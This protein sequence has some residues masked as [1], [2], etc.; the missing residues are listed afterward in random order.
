MNRVI[1]ARTSLGIQR[2]KVV[3]VRQGTVAAV[4]AVPVVSGAVVGVLLVNYG[5]KFN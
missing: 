4:L 3:N 2:V 1:G 5:I